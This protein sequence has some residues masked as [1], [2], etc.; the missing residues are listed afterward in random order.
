MENGYRLVIPSRPGYGRTPSASGRTAEEFAHTLSSLLDVLLIDQVIVIGISAAGRT[1]LHFAKNYPKRVTK[2]ILESAVTC[3][4]WPDSH[5]R[6]G[7]L[8][9]FNRFNEK[10]TWALLRQVG[11]FAPDFFL[12]LLL[13]SLSSLKTEEVI[14]SWDEKERRA[15]L[16]FLLASRSGEGFLN[17]IKHTFNEF[18][19]I[20]VPTLIIASTYDKS[21]SPENSIKAAEQITGAELMMIPAQSHLIW[22]SKYKTEIE[23]KIADFIQN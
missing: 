21:V 4:V 16:K 8:I 9:I 13:P 7:A 19:L 5:T 12:K 3:E 20:T 22:F 23:N 10:F 17:D 15:V 1:A 18:N 14:K 6:R 11:R 2:L